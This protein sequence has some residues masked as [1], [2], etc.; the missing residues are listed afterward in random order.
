MLKQLLILGLAAALALASSTSASATPDD[1]LLKRQTNPTLYT[2]RDCVVTSVAT[3]DFTVREARKCFNTIGAGIVKQSQNKCKGRCFGARLP[4]YS[5]LDDFPSQRMMKLGAGQYG[6]Q[7]LVDFENLDI[8]IQPGSAFVRK[9]WPCA[10]G[11]Q[12]SVT[13]PDCRH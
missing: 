9:D 13:C 2:C 5:L 12:G 3:H 1:S 8:D 11:L 10:N 7:K 4:K 6:W